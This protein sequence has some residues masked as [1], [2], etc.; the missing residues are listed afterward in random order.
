MTAINTTVDR[1][2]G[3]T[4]IHNP[5]KIANKK[6]CS[7]CIRSIFCHLTKWGHV[8]S[9]VLLITATA[10]WHIV[11]CCGVIIFFIYISLGPTSSK[12]IVT[13]IWY[14]NARHHAKKV[15][16]RSTAVAAILLLLNFKL[17][18]IWHHQLIK[19]LVLVVATG[20]GYCEVGEFQW[21]VVHR[22]F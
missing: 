10:N 1:P 5:H 13:N 7:S 8:N 20:S 18:T 3:T 17:K 4:S 19:S 9:L 22:N 11:L 16:Q 12:L 6:K 21:R 2:P 15:P 14:E